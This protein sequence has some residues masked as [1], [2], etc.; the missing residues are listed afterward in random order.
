MTLN[1][2]IKTIITDELNKQPHPTTAT[3]T[4]VYDDGYVDITCSYGELKH[5][6]S[7]TEHEINDTT[8]LI[9]IEN[10]FDLRMVI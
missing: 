5:I 6:Q 10:N 9:F 1:D 4:Q 7:I 3:I 8:I 2:S